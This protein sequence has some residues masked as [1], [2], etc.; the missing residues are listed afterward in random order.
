VD[1]DIYMQSWAIIGFILIIV[2]SLAMMVLTEMFYPVDKAT[3]KRHFQN[4]LS[5][6]DHSHTQ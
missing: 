2:I 3:H 4:P 6:K 1:S 5:S